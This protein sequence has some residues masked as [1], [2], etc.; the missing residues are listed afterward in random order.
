[1][2]ER[3][4]LERLLNYTI[5]GLLVFITIDQYDRSNGGPG[6]KARVE[7]LLSSVRPRKKSKTWEE[8]SEA[9]RE[10]ARRRVIVEAWNAAEGRY[11]RK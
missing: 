2:P 3:S 1:M 7:N 8:L 5:T 10:H 9:E 4:P 6:V 11:E